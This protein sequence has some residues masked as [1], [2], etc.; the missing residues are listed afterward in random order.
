MASL[1]DDLQPD[2]TAALTDGAT[3]LRD[4]ML[5]STPDS[6]LDERTL[7]KMEQIVDRILAPGQLVQDLQQLSSQGSNLWLQS[8][9]LWQTGSTSEQKPNV[10]GRVKIIAFKLI[11]RGMPKTARGH[12]HALRLAFPTARWLIENDQLDLAL[13][14]FEITAQRLD[15]LRSLPPAEGVIS[16][17]SLAAEYY[18]LRSKLAWLQGRSDIADY[19]YAQV[20]SS[21]LISNQVD[22][23]QLCHEIGCLAAAAYEHELAI[24]WLRRAID[25]IDGSK[26]VGQVRGDGVNELAIRHKLAQEYMTLN[27]GK[28]NEALINE[29]DIL[30]KNYGDN[31]AVLV[32]CLEVIRVSEKPDISQFIEI[33]RLEIPKKM[34]IASIE[35]AA[36][37]LTDRGFD[38]LSEPGTHAVFAIIW[39]HVDGIIDDYLEPYQWCKLLLNS[40]IFHN[41]SEF[42]KTQVQSEL[43]CMYDKLYLFAWALLEDS[44]FEWAEEVI[45]VLRTEWKPENPQQGKKLNNPVFILDLARHACHARSPDIDADERASHYSEVQNMIHGVQVL[46]PDGD[47]EPAFNMGQ[48]YLDHTSAIMILAIEAAIYLEDWPRVEEVFHISVHWVHDITPQQ[49][50]GLLLANEMPSIVKVFMIRRV[51]IICGYYLT[52]SSERGDAESFPYLLH[53]LFEACM[54]AEPADEKVPD[55]NT[56]LSPWFLYVQDS[57][58]K[59]RFQEN[60]EGSTYLEVA[61][62]VLD[63]AITTA[64]D[65]NYIQS[66]QHLERHSDTQ[67]EMRYD[68]DG[69]AIG[70]PPCTAC[71]SNPYPPEELAY[72]ATTSFNRAMDLY[73]EEKDID[74]KRWVEKSIRLAKLMSNAEGDGLAVLFK[75]KLDGLF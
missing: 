24:K 25:W 75:S 50:M 73:S 66:A 46:K 18:M 72:L 49:I 64:S 69:N 40:K 32:L 68:D 12:T 38:G 44:E 43:K 55:D 21:D 8:T 28:E 13:T 59:Q 20:P 2:Q 60:S 31:T 42:N 36:C 41:C 45:D 9:H 5:A 51:L 1:Q 74:C 58:Y 26:N 65:E 62:K 53:V 17:E 57:G 23:C 70:A 33:I 52:Y 27:P 71:E 54:T 48:I 3:E 14:F 15:L 39:K 11:E 56:V 16:A 30:K 4:L 19:L 7:T 6:P 37:N 35:K 61:E 67:H 22:V 34:R 63:Q 29:L 10:I 47:F